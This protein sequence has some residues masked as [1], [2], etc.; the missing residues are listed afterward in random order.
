MSGHSRWANIKRKKGIAD[1]ARGKLFTKIIREITVAA[2][3]G[4]GDLGNN[5][6]LRTAVDK[7]RGVSMPRDT[8]ERAISKGAGGTDTATWEETTFE[9]YGA[10]GVAVM[11]MCLTDNRNR[12]TAEIRYAFTR[13][14][15]RFGNA[16]CV[17]YLFKRC[18]LITV[19]AEGTDED[20][21][22]M[23]ALDAGADDVSQEDD[24]FNVTCPPLSFDACKKAIEDA[25]FTVSSAEITYIP[26][27]YVSVSGKEAE[28]VVR[29]IEIL[30]DNDDVQN[31]YTSADISDADMESFAG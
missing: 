12:T 6:R 15:G 13:T 11:A 1:A 27:N 20:S 10:G 9:G 29:L 2:R 17:S 22:M 21:L 28:Q 3:L 16:N 25:G 18:G 26:D 19:P 31:V 24:Q 4:G 7:A 8:I 23:A 14:G 5:S 30:E